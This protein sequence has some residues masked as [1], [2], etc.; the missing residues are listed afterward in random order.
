MA[1][2]PV[3]KKSL[4]R[5]KAAAPPSNVIVVDGIPLSRDLV[6]D[7]SLSD[8]PPEAENAFIDAEA[9]F[10]KYDID[11]SGGIDLD[12]FKL[13]LVDLQI[14]IPPPKIQVYFRKCDLAQKGFITF[15]EFRLAMFTCD[16]TNPTR[17]N[18]FCPSKVLNPKDLFAIF[19]TDD[20]GEIGRSEFSAILRF[21]KIKMALDRQETVFSQF[22]NPVTEGLT[23]LAFRSLWLTLVDVRKELHNR[24]I[25]YNKLLSRAKLAKKLESVLDK[26]DAQEQYTMLEAQW[27]FN[28]ETIKERREKLLANAKR[29]ADYVLGETLDAAGQVYVFGKGSFNRFDGAP[30]ERDFVECPYFSQLLALWTSRVRG[31]EAFAPKAPT[32][33]EKKLGG[34]DSPKKRPPM[35]K[36]ERIARD[37][38]QTQQL[39]FHNRV[40]A[41]NTAWL[42]ARRVKQVSCGASVAYALTDAGELYCWG[43]TRRTWDY[44]YSPEHSADPSHQ[45]PG[46]AASRPFTARTEMLKLSAPNQLLADEHEHLKNYVRSMFRENAPPEVPVESDEAELQRLL[47]L[48]D[49]FELY[50]P[51]LRAEVNLAKARE[52]MEFDLRADVVT[53]ALRLRALQSSQT[54]KATNATKLSKCL[55][56]ELEC[57]GEPFQRQMK[58]LDQQLLRALHNYQDATISSVL[59]KGAAL[60]QHMR[61][62]VTAIDETETS[63]FQAKQDLWEQKRS[64]VGRLRR[65]Q[66]RSGLEGAT[67]GA[68]PDHEKTLQMSGVTARGP[69]QKTFL[70]HQALQQVSVGAKHALAVHQSGQLYGWGF[71][72]YGRLGSSS[73]DDTTTPKPLAHLRE[74]RFRSV[75][76]GYSHSLALR[77]DG[78]VFVWGSGATGKLGLAPPSKEPAIARPHTTPVGHRHANTTEPVRVSSLEDCFTILP[79]PLA[80]PSK[81][82]K[83]ACGPSHSAVISTNG[84]LYVWGSGDGGR[85]GLGDGRFTDTDNELRGGHLGIVSVPTK[86]A[87]LL[88][89]HII[90]VSCGTAHTA[91]VS[92]IQSN[93]A[94][95]SGGRVFVAGSAH[96][97]G[98]FCPA[99]VTPTGLA[100]V[101]VTALACGNAHTA[102]VSIDGELFTWGNNVGGCTGHDSSHR[103]IGTPS[104]VPCIYQSPSN[105]ARHPSYAIVALQS[106]VATGYGAHLALDGVTDGALESNCCQTF[107]EMC[108][109]WQVDLGVM[110]RITSVRL[111][112]RPGATGDQLF[113]CIV[114]IGQEP[115]EAEA[116]KHALHEAK[117]H[118]VFTK[119]KLET[120]ANPLVWH[121][122]DNT[123]GRYVRVQID[124]AS[125][126]SLAQV[127][128]FGT[129]EWVY[130]GPRVHSVASGDDIL[131]VICRPTYAQS[132]IDKAYLRALSADSRFQSVLDEFPT[133]DTSK[134]ALDDLRRAARDCP[135]CTVQRVC[136][137]CLLCKELESHEHDLAADYRATMSLDEIGTFLLSLRPPKPLAPLAV[138]EENR[139]ARIYVDDEKPESALH[140]AEGRV[141]AAMSKVVRGGPKSPSFLRKAMVSMATSRLAFAKRKVPEMHVQIVRPHTTSVLGRG[142]L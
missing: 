116:G 20:S 45:V 123:I 77:H 22:E 134:M 5:N 92:A 89:H 141:L 8:A 15:D 30:A 115:F 93:G 107:R 88:E 118:S 91:V 86:V 13:L 124:G 75:A 23:Y 125:I 38:T 29:Y 37:P 2:E 102:A 120:A 106:S 133:F 58:K 24:N 95:S 74:M 98:D 135:L 28:W 139:L 142:G 104:R 33:P 26:E 73:H 101:Q 85:L 130:Q 42:W 47:V 136:P 9:M 84:E 129:E 126:L 7:P 80:L 140:K 128:V 12:E 35:I 121:P 10:R 36:T 137:L 127:E 67:L 83:I 27:N 63:A 61:Q 119:F 65:K 105:M 131:V 113:P 48:I 76:C 87:A 40:V 79:L 50:P 99:F 55:M 51:A 62:L 60:W 112:N 57:M 6:E 3:A 19:D 71:G 109:F 103:F 68:V 46:A 53:N 122:P 96:A 100:S 114:C 32:S 43:G 64:E 82:R 78:Q 16:P 56:L 97:L 49:Y 41:I 69:R 138:D 44:V 54:G 18:G 132:D 59:K 52:L 4:F 108:P 25:A 34:W 111:W 90:D 66:A 11:R 117:A 94:L 14:D 110:C 72:T 70:G 21:L 81:V 39:A 1:P 17:T 31:A